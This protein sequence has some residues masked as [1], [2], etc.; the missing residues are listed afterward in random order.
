[1]VFNILEIS[2]VHAVLKELAIDEHTAAYVLF[3]HALQLINCR[4]KSTLSIIK[5]IYYPLSL[6]FQ[7]TMSHIE[8]T[9]R[10]AV[11]GVYNAKK[12]ALN[13]LAG[14][15]LTRCPTVSEF[16]EMIPTSI[17]DGVGLA[18]SVCGES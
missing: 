6:R 17:S 9:M 15:E 10:G 8:H 3:I 4:E 5:E 11:E 7:C 1:M 14:A 18:A 12:D 16:L 2:S 13:K